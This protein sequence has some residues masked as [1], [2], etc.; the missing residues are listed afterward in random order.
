MSER[1]PP[2]LKIRNPSFPEPARATACVYLL[3]IGSVNAVRLAAC[4]GEGATGLASY[5]LW[6]HWAVPAV[7]PR[8]IHDHRSVLG[9]IGKTAN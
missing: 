6:N 2:L 4:D 8:A 9:A 5:F 7:E 3:R 1:G